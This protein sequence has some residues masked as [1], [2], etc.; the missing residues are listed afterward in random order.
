MEKN[1]LTQLKIC[2]EKTAKKDQKHLDR[3]QKMAKDKKQFEKLKAAF[4]TA[5]LWPNNFT[6]NIAFIDTPSNIP[7]TTISEINKNIKNAS[8]K[9]DPLQY[10]V[11]KMEIIPAVKKIVLERIQPIVNL[12][13]IFVED[14]KKAQVRISFDPAQGAWSL[15]G[16]DCLSEKS[17]KE[18]TMNLGWFDVAT[19]I[20]EFGHTLGLIHEHQNPAG[21]PIDWNEE[22]VYAWAADTQGWDRETTYSNIIEKYKSSQVNGSDFDPESIMLYFFPGSLTISGKGTNENLRLSK[23]DAQYINS[24]YANSPD[25]VQNFYQ[26]AYNVKIDTTIAPFNRAG[27]NDVSIFDTIKKDYGKDI[28]IG[29]LGGGALIFIIYIVAKYI[30]PGKKR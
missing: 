3:L 20:H 29:L 25:T 21:K 22:K 17:H 28:L 10:E 9:I 23:Y 5:K 15:I 11:D 26:N 14:P 24:V 13:L 30:L 19:T 6:I 2:V 18:P 12:K 7:R 8:V 4:Y 16:T 27:S 1:T